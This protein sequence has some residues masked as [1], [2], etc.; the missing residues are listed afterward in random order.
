MHPHPVS[1]Q[2]PGPCW[3]RP[4]FSQIPAGQCRD[5]AHSC[6][7]GGGGTGGVI[8]LREPLP[9]HLF[10]PGLPIHKAVTCSGT[11][12]GPSQVT[13]PAQCMSPTV[14][15]GGDHEQLAFLGVVHMWGSLAGPLFPFPLS[16]VVG[17]SSHVSYQLRFQRK[18][19]TGCGI[20]RLSKVMLG[21]PQGLAGSLA[22]MSL[23]LSGAP[24]WCPLGAFLPWEAPWSLK[25][26]QLADGPVGRLGLEAGTWHP[27]V[28][29][30]RSWGKAPGPRS[31]S[32]SHP[33]LSAVWSTARDGGREEALR[34][35]QRAVPADEGQTAGPGG[36]SVLD[37][38]LPLRREHPQR[39]VP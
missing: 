3:A 19:I 6:L 7:E 15:W 23:H 24:S 29:G 31:S 36:A 1:S 38:L 37:A 9:G 26:S 33:P 17:L 35:R 21:C 2:G 16:S 4:A 22:A 34:G 14:I 27:A 13:W 10:W 25:A 20:V 30:Q 12:K 32:G 18:F 28:P 11:V 5:A 39:L 8:G